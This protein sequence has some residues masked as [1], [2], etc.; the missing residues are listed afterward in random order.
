MS[1]RVPKYRLHKATGQALVEIRGHRTYLGKYDSPS[2]HECSRQ[3]IAE[4]MSEATRGRQRLSGQSATKSLRLRVRTCQ[5]S[6][7]TWFGCSG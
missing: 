7:R 5:R 3:L 6:S 2:S 1:V 4:F